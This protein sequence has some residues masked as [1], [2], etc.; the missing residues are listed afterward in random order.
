MAVEEHPEYANWMQVENHQRQRQK[1]YDAVKGKY[2][3]NHFMVTN[4]KAK[5]KE[6]QDEYD[7][8]V[9]RL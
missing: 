3:D 2:P 9:S 5:L 8:V 7:A 4:A 6:A 1:F